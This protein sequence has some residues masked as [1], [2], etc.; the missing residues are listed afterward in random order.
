VT[1]HV[2][3]KD[4]SGNNLH[5][6]LHLLDLAGTGKICSSENPGNGL[7]NQLMDKSLSCLEEVLTSLSQKN[8]QIP[9]RDSKLTSFLQD[10][11]GTA[12]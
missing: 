8:S 2:H 1:V 12:L 11:L 6:R 5:G 4:A 3:G 9:Y 10:A 7:A